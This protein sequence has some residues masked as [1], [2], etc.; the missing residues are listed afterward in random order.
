[1]LF[2]LLV[3]TLLAVLSN[4]KPQLLVTTPVAGSGWYAATAPSTYYPGYFSSPAYAAYTY[5]PVYGA[6]A[7]YPYYTYLRR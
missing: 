5:T 6:Y 3:L 1:M 2:K 7:T 4:A